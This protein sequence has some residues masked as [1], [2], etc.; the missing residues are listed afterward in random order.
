M[1]KKVSKNKK[2]ALTIVGGATIGTVL[3]KDATIMPLALFISVPLFFA[4][5][6]W[7]V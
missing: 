7:I 1:K 6:N 2:V 4:K 3:T 5:K